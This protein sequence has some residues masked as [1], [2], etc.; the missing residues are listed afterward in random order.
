LPSHFLDGL[1]QVLGRAGQRGQQFFAGIEVRPF[2]LAV[3]SQSQ[4]CGEVLA[5]A[6]VLSVIGQGVDHGLADRL[7]RDPVDAV[8]APLYG[9]GRRQPA[10]GTLKAIPEVP[11][12]TTRTAGLLRL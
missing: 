4:L 8:R 9:V 10:F 5:I 1:H 7:E 6:V 2:V 11:P 12:L 3:H